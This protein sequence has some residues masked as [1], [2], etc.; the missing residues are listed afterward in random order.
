VYHQQKK[1]NEAADE[2]RKALDIKPSLARI[3]ENLGKL[4]ML[5]DTKE[6]Q[7]FW[8]FWTSSSYK[9]LIFVTIGLAISIFVFLYAFH[10]YIVNDVTTV[11][12]EVIDNPTNSTTTTNQ[13]T[14]IPET[15][16][17]II[18]LMLFIIL[19]PEIRKAKIGPIEFEL[20]EEDVHN[21]KDQASLPEGRQLN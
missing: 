2:A 5:T 1:Y 12:V 19:L 7:G 15:Y 6:S 10:I 8:E 21:I 13:P 18:V 11:V 20:K 17:I 3:D 16:F 4:S 14:E 9:K